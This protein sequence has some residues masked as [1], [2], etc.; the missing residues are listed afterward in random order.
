MTPS[1]ARGILR[2]PKFDDAVARLQAKCPRITDVVDGAL[3]S[4][5]RNPETDGV[6]ISELEVWQA[7]LIYPPD[8]ALLLYYTIKPRFVHA[9]T[10]CDPSSAG[11]Q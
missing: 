8:V 5:G 2:H 9:L 1:N 6:W 7:R 4:I 3:W 11:G 10:I